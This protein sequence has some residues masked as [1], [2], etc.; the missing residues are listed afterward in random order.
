MTGLVTGQTKW[1]VTQCVGAAWAC[2]SACCTLSAFQSGN[3]DFW[4]FWPVLRQDAGCLPSRLFSAFHA[5][6]FIFFSLFPL[7]ILSPKCQQKQSLMEPAR[8]TDRVIAQWARPSSL[9]TVYCGWKFGVFVYS[10]WAF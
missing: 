3:R 6:D 4:G 10:L 2:H 1:W 8:R 9:F 5:D 7:L